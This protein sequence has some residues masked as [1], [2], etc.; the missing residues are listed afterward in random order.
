[1]LELQKCLNLALNSLGFMTHLSYNSL[2]MVIHSVNYRLILDL[3]NPL[4]VML[5][6]MNQMYS[7]FVVLPLSN[8]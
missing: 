6:R 5:R 4:P 1:M 7:L 8:T 2:S 3:L